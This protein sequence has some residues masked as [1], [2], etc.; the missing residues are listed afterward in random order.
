MY[1]RK[2]NSQTYSGRAEY[3]PLPLDALS[4]VRGVV[5][6]NTFIFV[7]KKIWNMIFV[8]F[9]TDTTFTAVTADIL[10]AAGEFV[11][12]QTAVVGTSTGSL[13]LR[14]CISVH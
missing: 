11:D 7:F 2:D 9:F 4:A 10:A 1:T 5:G 6:K 12:G 14:L 8:L 3:L 13:P